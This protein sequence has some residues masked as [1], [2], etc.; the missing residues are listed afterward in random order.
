VAIAHVQTGGTQISST[1]VS[2]TLT[3]T[4]GNA[5]VVSIMSKNHGKAGAGTFTQTSG[6]TLTVGTPLVE[7]DSSSYTFQVANYNV[8]GGSTTYTI[9]STVSQV[10]CLFVA[11]FSGMATASAFDVSA[12]QTQLTQAGIT[13][14]TTGTLAQADEVAVA[15]WNGDSTGGR[16]ISSVSNSFTVP[17]G[18]NLLNDGTNGPALMAYKVVAAT[19]GVESTATCT[20]SWTAAALIGTYKAAG[21]GGAPTVKALAALG[22]G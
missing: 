18:G 11:E 17:T 2:V 13:S 15:A 5:V 8:A 10:L 14:G 1:D 12:T 19:T 4:A 21:G 22:V 16:T 6:D 7:I 3:T 9:H 20:G